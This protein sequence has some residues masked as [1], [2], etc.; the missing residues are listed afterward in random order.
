MYE[1]RIETLSESAKLLEKE[2]QELEKIDDTKKVF[3]KKQQFL[4]YLR[5]IARLTKLQWEEDH[6]R[7]DFDDDR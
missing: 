1:K 4:T 6:E 7:V 5:E 3:E 2:I